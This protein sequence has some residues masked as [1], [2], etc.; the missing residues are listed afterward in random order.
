[1]L[2]HEHIPHLQKKH[3]EKPSRIT[4]IHQHLRE[5]GL[6]A[7]CDCE[8]VRPRPA[9][10]REIL[11]VHSAEHFAEVQAITAQVA[12]APSNRELREPDGPGGIYYSP[13]SLNAAQ[14]AAGCVIEMCHALLA[15]NT[16]ASSESEAGAHGAASGDSADLDAGD[17]ANGPA[18]AVDAGCAPRAC[19]PPCAL[20]LVRPPGHHAGYD[21]TPG[22]RA[23]GFCFFNSVAIAARAAIASGRASRVLIVD[24]DVHHGNGTERLFWEADDVLFMSVHRLAHPS[25]AARARAPPDRPRLAAC[26]PRGLQ[27]RQKLLPGDGRDRRRGRGRG[28]GL[29]GEPALAA[30][31]LRRR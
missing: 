26:A 6:L 4:T 22:H 29:H 14:L 12:S 28:L 9:T 5:L 18:V 17:R 27:V 24:Y 2:A 3:P 1:M 7:R 20:A 16:R 31:R 10:E 19:M 30:D 23:E 21:D 8:S 15:P 13:A 11:L 25:R